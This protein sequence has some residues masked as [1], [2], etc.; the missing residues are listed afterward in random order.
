MMRFV[1]STLLLLSFLWVESTSRR[2]WD[3]QG[4]LYE[5][6]KLL[7]AE[8]SFRAHQLWNDTHHAIYA[9]AE[10]V[11]QAKDTLDT[12]QQQVSARLEDFFD[13]QYTVEWGSC[14]KQHEREVAHFN[15]ELIDKYSICRQSL[16][17]VMEH[18]EQEVVQEA[19]FLNVAA[20]KISDLSKICQIWQLKQSSFNHAGVLLCTVAGIGGINQRMASSLELCWDILLELSLEELETPSCTAYHQLK[21]QFDVVYA[22]IESCVME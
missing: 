21:M 1:R 19:N 22:G 7:I 14:F 3:K 13:H 17:S 6:T 5:S 20:Q 4:P 12:K 8:E 11:Q 16:D 2:I 18:F 15:R 9:H 10:Q